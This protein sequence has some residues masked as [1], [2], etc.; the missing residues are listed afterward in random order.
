MELQ[1]GLALPAYGFDANK[2]S[3]GSSGQVIM[4]MNQ[5]MLHSWLSAGTYSASAEDDFS[6]NNQKRSFYDA[7]EETNDVPR[8]LPLLLWN[9]QPNEEEDD[10]HKDLDKSFPFALNRYLYSGFF[11]LCLLVFFCVV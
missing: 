5:G 7:F 3:A 6:T 2:V 10:E 4:I 1:L 8:T 9:K 11:F